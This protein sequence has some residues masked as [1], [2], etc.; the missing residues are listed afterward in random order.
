MPAACVLSRS[1][2]TFR[3][4]LSDLDGATATARQVE[5]RYGV[6]LTHSGPSRTPPDTHT[7]LNQA[8]ATAR[9]LGLGNVERRALAL[10]TWRTQQRALRGLATLM[11]TPFV[12]AS[13]V[14]EGKVP[15]HAPNSQ[16]RWPV[17]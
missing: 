1:V 13:S 5:A 12:R 10:L 4:T 8:L 2:V 14:S 9:K 15:P 16:S 6:H 3:P 11:P 17:C 7:L